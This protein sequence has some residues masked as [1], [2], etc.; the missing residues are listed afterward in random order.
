MFVNRGK[1]RSKALSILI[2]FSMIV[3]FFPV[4][5]SNPTTVEAATTLNVYPAP[6]GVTMNTTYTVQVQAPGGPWQSLDVYQTT[7]NGYTSS[8]TS[9]AYFDTDGPVNVSVTSN[10]GSISTAVIRPAAH[11]ITPAINGNT[12]TFSMSGP[13]NISVEVNGDHN[14][15]LD[16][17]ANPV[18]PNP[19]SP[20]DPNVIY[21]G[22]G[23]Y[24]QNYVVPSGKTLYIAGG[25]VIIGGITVNN[26][27]NA[28][29]LGRG[30]ILNA[31]FRAI[32]VD[33]SNQITIDG[34][35]VNDYGA[36]NNG[37]YAINIGNSTNVSVNNFKAYSFK[38]WTDG[39]DIFASS[40]V[41]INN[42]FARTG[43]DAIAIYGARNFGG[44]LYSGNTAHIS[45]TN[46]FLQPDVAHPINVGTHGDPTKP[47]GGETIEDLNFSNIT[48]WQKNGSKYTSL[49]A[50]DGLL[51]NKVRFTDIT[52]ED[53]NQGRFI[54]V[55]TFKNNGFGLAF[56]RGV[57]DVHVKNMSYTGSNSGTNNIYG[58]F[59]NQLTQNVT[60]E[61]LKVNG[62]VV[63]S[64]SAGNFA[65]GSYAQNINFIA[66]GGTVPAPTA[67]PFTTPVDIARGKTATADSTQ[68][69]KPASSGN[70]GNTTTRWCANDGSTGHWWTVDLGSPMN[71]TGGTQVMWELNNTAYKYKI[72]TSV[73]NVN[74]TLKVD[75]TNNT[76]TNQVQNDVFQGTARYVRITVTG[77]Q[78]NVWASF[79]DF[80]VFG[81]PTNLALGKIVTADS[82]K[83]G[84]P[85]V[86][87]I[88]SNP[89]TLWSANDG[90]I[91]HWLTM[92][93]GNA[94]KITNGT[95]VAWAQSGAAY[96]YKIETS[97]DNTNW[98][99]KVDKTGNADTSQVQNDYFTGTAR[100][101]RIT[102]TGLPSGAWASFYDFKVFGE[103][104]NLTLGKT[105]TAD[106]SQ[107]G[108]PASNG[109]DG[110]TSTSWI[111]ADTNGGHS[112][113]VDLGSMMNITGG[114]QV[115]WPQSG[116]QY[117]YTI[118]T[119]PDNIN[120]T[121]RLEK[122]SNNNITQVQNDY[123]T[124]TTR[125][126][127]ITVTGVP[128][129]YS[130]GI[131]DFKVFGTINGP[132]FYE[133]YN[134]EGKAV[135]LDLGNYTL[136]QMQAAGIANDSISSIHV[137]LEYTVVAYNGDG[138]SG[139]SW[140]IT[141]DNPAMG[142][143][144]NDMISSIK[145]MSA[146]PTFYEHYN[147]GG[148]AVTLRPGQYT[149][150]QMQAAGIADNGISSIRVPAEYTVVAYSDDGFSGTSWTITSDNPAMGDTGNN[151][152][153]SSV[154]I[155][156][157]Q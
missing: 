29:V 16:L 120:W 73:D 108:N 62:N 1:K 94:K 85:A 39:I 98:T 74:W 35:I 41:A 79:Y 124:G 102:V 22:P 148:K 30:V 111:A 32:E 23:L 4:A 33:H 146:G 100:Y 3:S 47:G 17:F 63:L 61:N 105:A 24:T 97:I 64:A 76:D 119:S 11:G 55:L 65:I 86:N 123:F 117:K 58:K 77:L 106:S 82:S 19:P 67:I 125:Y 114:T 13:M 43:D 143:G 149:L 144:N 147:Y 26:A 10:I 59:V 78:S 136:A 68:S 127:K 150:A 107:S 95:Q 70:D 66:S 31:P 48:I 75:K 20:T 52:I 38:R 50:S 93:L 126:V 27:T 109:N 153:I 137:P 42:Y 116:V 6:S 155:T 51:V 60:F 8:K 92:D 110:D 96:Q 15:T 5:L 134:Y 87:G 99:L 71:I 131:A 14:N 72:E 28:K 141:S 129:G 81:D 152:M 21:V 46:S 133:H 49:T 9:F 118:S 128:S 113:V 140:T 103:P 37:G 53:E 121:M 156:S 40:Y 69:G 112:W 139:T 130:A 7:V 25:A 83:S 34:I 45:V 12:M 36:S 132:T 104:T 89:A 57:N 84:N 122:T 138:F 157:N 91:G 151:D 145:V 154:I 2:V 115:K 44:N 142:T 101:V 90:N 135:T 80:K 54:E 18:D 88:D 56:G